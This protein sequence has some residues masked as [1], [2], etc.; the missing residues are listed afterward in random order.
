MA[1]VRLTSSAGPTGRN[2][3]RGEPEDRT[4]VARD[5]NSAP[6][7]VRRLATGSLTVCGLI[8]EL[9]IDTRP[10][11]VDGLGAP[12]TTLQRKEFQCLPRNSQRNVE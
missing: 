6:L 10:G 1:A 4:V 7:D 9:A 3:V 5:A 11:G 12:G 8:A 2:G